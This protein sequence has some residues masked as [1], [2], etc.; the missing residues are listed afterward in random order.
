MKLDVKFVESNQSFNAQFGEVQVVNG[1]GADIVDALIDKS[2]TEISSEVDI[3]GAYACYGL[4]KLES[5]N[6]PNCTS[7]GNDAFYNCVTLESVESPNVTS[8]AS[9]AFRLCVVLPSIDLP[10][11]TSIG[12]NAFRDCRKLQSLILRSKTVCTLGTNVFTST[13]IASGTGYIYVPD[14]L[15]EQYKAAANWSTYAAQIKPLS[16]LEE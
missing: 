12:S 16:E 14:N 11:L 4:T 6:L 10:L 1:G 3:V 5:V 7:I 9:S 15:V 13:P 8:I 2:V